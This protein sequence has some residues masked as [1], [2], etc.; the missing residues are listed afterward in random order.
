MSV[1][2]SIYE[3]AGE[4]LHFDEFENEDGSGGDVREGDGEE[5]QRGGL[6][7]QLG[8]FSLDATLA[9]RRK[10]VPT[11]PFETVFGEPSE[12]TDQRGYAE[13]RWQHLRGPLG[14]TA[15]AAYDHQRYEG[16]YPYPDEMGGLYRFTDE[17]KGDWF[18]GELRLSVE[19]FSQKLTMGA[20][21]AS[22][23]VLHGFNDAGEVVEDDRQFINGS[24][25]GVEEV[26]LFEDA[27]RLSAGVR[28]DMFG[29]QND[30]AISPRLGLIFRPYA[31]GYTKLIAG[32]AFRSPS[33]Y[34]LYYS[35]NG[36]TQIQALELDP[37]I[38][39]TAEAEHTHSFGPRSFFIA[40]AFGSQL[41]DIV[42]LVEVTGMEGEPVLQFNNSDDEV[43]AVGGE[44]ELRY[45]LRS[46]A[47][48]GAAASYT[49]LDSD[50]EAVEVNSAAAVG[51]VRGFLPVLGERLG[52]GSEFIVNSP[53]P[54]RD[55][56]D[57]PTAVI[58]RLFV[59]GRLRS[60]GLLYRAGVT[61]M[62]DWDWAVPVGEELFPQ[63]IDQPPR[64]FHAQLVY[65]FN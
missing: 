10:D 49:W 47:W 30:T 62:L 56:R 48:W 24:V 32:R 1:H 28:V 19:A 16:S 59:S 31:D 37:E 8:D 33:P 44:I 34:E 61:N 52:L 50:D 3:S 18:T 57:S 27:L 23:N 60:A 13:L 51:S 55:G 2:A 63:Q 25:Y 11:A 46:G 15:R 12:T 6:R 40:S 22:H 45:A 65:E 17:G 7:A 26:I 5:A 20:E 54:R 64:T 9:R 36:I 41:T 42:N 38:I 53:R 14:I 43:R 58:G 35:D 21:A 29:D 4:E 39:W